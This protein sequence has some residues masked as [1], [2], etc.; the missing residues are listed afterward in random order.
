MIE[1]SQTDFHKHSVFRLNLPVLTEKKWFKHNNLLG[2]VVFDE[3]D[4]DWSWVAL[5]KAEN[6]Q[7]VAF[8]VG[9][10]LTSAGAATKALD[11]VLQRGRPAHQTRT[12]LLVAAAVKS[13]GLTD[14][15]FTQELRKRADEWAARRGGDG[16]AVR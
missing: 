14:E 10:S 9:H 4:S 2:T 8:D 11:A 7:Y 5:A 6:D 16:N 15:E 13:S 3:V 12:E 1:I